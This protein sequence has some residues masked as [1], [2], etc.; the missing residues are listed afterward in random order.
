[1]S[2]MKLWYETP[3]R[4]W[5]EALPIANG[6]LGAMAYGG[7]EGRFDLSEVTCWSGAPQEKYLDD[8][9]GAFMSEARSALL[10]GDITRAESLLEKCNG[11]KQNYG[12]QVPLGRLWVGVSSAPRHHYRELN[13][14][15]GVCRDDMV[16]ANSTMSRESFISNPD[17]VMAVRLT[18]NQDVMP[19]V[20][21]WLEGW[22]QPCDT[23]HQ[24]HQLVM[25]G[26][27]LELIHS[28]GL[29]GVSYQGRL[30]MTTDGQLEW[31]RQGIV[32][33][34]ANEVTVYLTVCTDMFTDDMDGICSQRLEAARSKGWNQLFDNH[35]A[36]HAQWMDRCT[37][38]LPAGRNAHL[39]TNLRLKQYK[40]DKSDYALT[41]LFFQYGR[42]LLLNSSRP[43]SLL[44]AALQGA[45]NDD[46][47]CRMGWT[48]DM[49]L[50][51]NTQMNYF[52][53][54]ATGLGDCTKPL[55]RWTADALA[56][57]GSRIAKELYQCNGWVAHT[58]SNAFG[59]A[60]P[61]WEGC[62]W[63]FHVTGGAWVATHLW[64]HY[65]YTGDT[66]FLR[67]ALPVLRGAAEFLYGILLPHPTTGE[68]LITPSFSPE[69]MYEY[70]GEK[71]HITA[72]ATV[73]TV[74]AKYLFEAVIEAGRVLGVQDELIDR[75]AEAKD[76][77]PT[78]KIGKHGQLMEWYEDFDEPLPDHRHTSHLL[79][80]YPFGMI[81]PEDTPELAEAVKVS[82]KRRLGENATDI[83]L[84][85]WA[86]AL[87]ILYSARLQDGEAAGQFL[88]PMM[89]FL[90]RDNLMI[91]H[92]GPTTS[93]TGGIYELDGNTGFTAGVVE[94][95]LHSHRGEL[96]ILPAVPSSWST[97]RFHGLV[98]QGGHQVAV[99][100]ED[101]IPH[102]VTVQAGSDGDITLRYKTCSITCSYAKN[103]SRRFTYLNGQL[104]EN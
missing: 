24:G 37:L 13:L 14:R 36:E 2:D 61:G 62:G 8:D 98:G 21:V 101:H 41:A 55:F 4:E 42:Y 50:D 78:F 51:I 54:D 66:D 68:L 33:K 92:E 64:S 70:R 94:M 69:N 22:S 76:K 27:A 48:D 30:Y 77:M 25:R 56:P 80:L 10:A 43:D 100:W 103:Q 96:H 63:G 44:P 67:T 72:G 29:H 89:A 11:I 85:N 40:E 82:I 38:E 53:A 26:R 73:D 31:S 97:G 83:V 32:F 95:L 5:T 12:T 17:K 23:S 87:L 91:T 74:I 84:A 65:L 47:A 52:P 86:G 99:Q 104:K 71:H 75:I 7:T 28:D 79:S 90:S 1:M 20:R 39:P 16:Y 60:A 45:W 57:Q 49:H 102:S 3:A 58:I 18:S 93:V 35:C 9:A 46:R 6:H 15:T 34:N 19:D 81:N 88:E 59:W